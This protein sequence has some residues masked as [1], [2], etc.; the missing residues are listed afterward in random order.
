MCNL[1]SHSD[2][3]R[4]RGHIEENLNQLRPPL[5]APHALNDDGGASHGNGFGKRKICD[6]DEDQQEVHRN[7]ARDSGQPHLKSRSE[8]R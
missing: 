1:V 5:S 2:A 6:T 3:E 8:Q 4:E 7:G